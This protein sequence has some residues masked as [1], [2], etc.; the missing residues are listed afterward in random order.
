MPPKKTKTKTKI[1]VLFSVIEASSD[2]LFTRILSRGIIDLNRL[3]KK[4]LASDVMTTKLREIVL[5]TD[6]YTGVVGDKDMSV[7]I[8]L[9]RQML[10]DF[11]RHLKPRVLNRETSITIRVSDFERDKV[12]GI[13]HDLFFRVYEH[14]EYSC[15]IANNTLSFLEALETWMK[16]GTIRCVPCVGFEGSLAATVDFVYMYRLRG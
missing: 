1:N 3:G 2:A 7:A 9:W 15:S 11:L 16:S 10:L 12:E 5:E 6:E 4:D 13:P 8:Q 14:G